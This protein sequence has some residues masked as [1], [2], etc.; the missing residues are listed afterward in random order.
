MNHRSVW[1][2]VIAALLATSVGCSK[3]PTRVA[4]FYGTA[5]ELA[6]VGQINNPDAGVHTGAR[7][8]DGTPG[9]EGSI[10]TRVVD[11]YQKGFERPAPKTTSYSVNIG[12]SGTQQQ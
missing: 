2:L 8:L 3:P 11:R 4:T 12:G 9:L 1:T 10:A 6:K 5:Y 7:G